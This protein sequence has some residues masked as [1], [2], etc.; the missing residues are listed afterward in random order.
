[1]HFKCA[2]TLAHSLFRR[3]KSL[4]AQST[5]ESRRLLAAITLMKCVMYLIGGGSSSSEFIS[6]TPRRP[7][8]KLIKRTPFPHYSR[9]RHTQT[10]QSQQSRC[11]KI[12]QHALRVCARNIICN[13][14]DVSFLK[15]TSICP[16]RFCSHSNITLLLARVRRNST[17]RLLIHTN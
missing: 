3:R 13:I 2:D 1:M 10:T 5:R 15:I 11:A 9:S 6:N 14:V 8:P 16:P 7:K 17:S 4:C 12:V